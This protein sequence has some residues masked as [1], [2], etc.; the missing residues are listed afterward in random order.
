MAVECHLPVR[1]ETFKQIYSNSS[2][3]RLPSAETLAARF[4]LSKSGWYLISMIQIV[5][6]YRQYIGFTPPPRATLPSWVRFFLVFLLAF[7]A[8][9]SVMDWVPVTSVGNFVVQKT[10]IY[11]TWFNTVL[12]APSTS[13]FTPAS[14]VNSATSTTFHSTANP[15]APS[16]TLTS[17]DVEDMIRIAVLRHS[18]DSISMRDFAYGSRHIPD[19]T[20]TTSPSLPRKQGLI[21]RLASNLLS[22]DLISSMGR[23]PLKAFTERLDEGH[24]WEFPGSNGLLG[25]ALKE[26]ISVRHL[27]LDHIPRE[28][29]SDTAI[30]QAPRKVVLWGKVDGDRNF[31]VLQE[32]QDRL[33]GHRPFSGTTWPKGLQD[34]QDIF[35]PLVEFEYKLSGSTYSHVQSKATPS[36]LA[37]LNMDFDTVV[38]E[39]VSNWGA[40]STCLYRV[41]VHGNPVNSLSLF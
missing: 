18:K 37:S 16:P 22:F 28:L 25:I 4:I 23:G 34:S 19:L 11:S 5:C 33:L 39:I 13:D 2:V 21:L 10:A 24:C 32:Y 6:S 41:R 1:L 27:S 3:R 38:L 36:Y 30:Q 35:V 8:S 15:P 20:T 26:R 31:A 14:L 17:D 12:S 40:A 29:A 7:V 9:M